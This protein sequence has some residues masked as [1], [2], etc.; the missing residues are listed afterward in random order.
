MSNELIKNF[1]IKFC[2]AGAVQHKPQ[3]VSGIDTKVWHFVV[4]IPR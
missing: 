1:S 3:F 2:F 4:F